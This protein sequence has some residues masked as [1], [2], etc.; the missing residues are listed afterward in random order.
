MTGRYT[1]YQTGLEAGSRL[2]PKILQGAVHQKR[3]WND[4]Y[5]DALEAIAAEAGK[6]GLTV[7]EIALRWLKHHSLLRRELGDAIVVGANRVKHLES[8]LLDLEKG[9]LSDEVVQVVEEAW[10]CVRGAVPPYWHGA[11]SPRIDI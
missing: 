2:D 3:Y 7:G 9:P 5:F 1:R 6:N 4:T 10:A 11:Y 8:N